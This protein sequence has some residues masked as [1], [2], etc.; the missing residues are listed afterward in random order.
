MILLADDNWNIITGNRHEVAS[1]F[2]ERINRA[3]RAM[4]H[5]P[6]SLPT[7]WSKFSNENL[8]A[9]FALPRHMNYGTFR[10]IAESL[11][12]GNVCFW[13]MTDSD[14]WI[15]LQ[16]FKPNRTLAEDAIER[17]PFAMESA[18]EEFKKR[19]PRPKLLQASVDLERVGG[20]AVVK[21]NTYTEWL[22]MLTSSQTEALANGLSRPLKI[23]GI[24]GT[25]KTLTLQLKALHELY[26][27]VD[28]IDP[29][30]PAEYPRVLFLT[31]SWAMAKQVEDSLQVLD[32]RGLAE[33]I[34]VMPLI[35]LREW[36]QGSLPDNVEVLGDDGL[37][38]K[39]RQVQLVEEALGHIQESTWD[40][41]RSHVSQWVRG[42][43][44]S[45]QG[46]EDRLR[47]CWAL[48]REFAEVFDSHEIKPGMN[49]LRKYLGL[50]RES[51]MVPLSENADREL[52]FAVYT[53]YV[54]RLVEEGQLTTD[55]LVDDFRR[56]LETYIWNSERTAKGY[57]LILVDEFHLF[58]N[59]ERYLLHLLTR[60][61]EAVPRL[62]MAM[63]PSQSAFTLLTGLAE[64]ELSRGSGA[65][66]QGGESA[67]IDLTVTHRFTAP[68]FEFVQYLHSAMPNLVELGHDWVY[69]SLPSS[70]GKTDGG[71]PMV[72]FHAQGGLASTA[73][74]AAFEKRQLS[75]ADARVA[76]I[77][78]GKAD[79]EAIKRGLRESEHPTSSFV[80]IEGRDDIELL[81]Y[82]RRALVATTA[83]YAAGLQFSHVVLVSGASGS[84]EYGHGASGKRAAYSQFYLAASRA[85]EDL[86]IFAHQDGEFGEVLSRGILNGLAG[87]RA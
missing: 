18:A 77:G 22:S 34:E 53:H 86:L 83:E 85:Q 50:T 5:P 41:Y 31:H 4:A 66:H 74:E 82:S 33:H 38:G 49:S 84:F 26:Q 73:V 72:Q 54:R 9:F 64:G 57:D 60:D 51:W 62:V 17:F 2:F 71:I 75:G 80:V 59:T 1:R 81:R 46:S 70:A 39:Y 14:S 44:E 24:A 3:A 11:P 47:L 69:D 78:V 56:Y 48:M 45:S 40:T 30:S 63:D 20:G 19:S 36:L 29:S 25:G 15:P 7:A 79:L 21:G 32:E 68:I 35:Y 37:D 8:L 6:V 43:V 67:A 12:D 52:A 28:S 10:W 13:T 16:R 65:L 61:V 87:E 23:R 27:E 76:L 58:S 42:A 55:Q